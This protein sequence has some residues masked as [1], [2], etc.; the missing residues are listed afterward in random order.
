MVRLFLVYDGA[1]QV[2]SA[3]LGQDHPCSEHS[4]QPCLPLPEP[5]RVWKS[6]RKGTILPTKATEEQ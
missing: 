6:A 3:A 1:Q 2:G 4:R 5:C